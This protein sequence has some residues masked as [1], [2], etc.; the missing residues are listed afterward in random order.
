MGKI[1]DSGLYIGQDNKFLVRMVSPN[2]RQITTVRTI[3]NKIS[4]LSFSA[5]KKHFAA[6]GADFSN[7]STFGLYIC[8]ILTFFTNM[9]DNLYIIP[10][11]K[12]YHTKSRVF[13][14]LFHLF[15]AKVLA[16]VYHL[17]A[18]FC[19]IN[20]AKNCLSELDFEYRHL[21]ILIESTFTDGF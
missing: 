13:T 5:S 2:L 19:L 18:I 16:H 14:A 6:F 9:T 10:V 1:Y 17:Q 20:F 15:R 21:I 3:D 11:I 4:G 8:W 7:K 12:A